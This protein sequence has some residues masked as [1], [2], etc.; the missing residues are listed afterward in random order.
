MN[1]LTH[2][3]SL[4]D[5]TQAL[6]ANKIAFGTLLS[7]LPYALLHADFD[8]YW[9]ETGVP[10]SLFNGVLQVH[11]QSQ[12]LLPAVTRVITHFRRRNIPFHWHVGPCSYAT[13]LGDLLSAHG[14]KHVEDEP[15]MY[16]DLHLLRAEVPVVPHFVI[17]EVTTIEQIHQWTRVWGYG[18]P[19][20]VIQQWDTIYTRLLARSQGALRLFLGIMEEK[21][22]ATTALFFAAGVAS[23]EHIVTIQPFRQR[24]I[25]TAMTHM[26]MHEARNTGY[27]IGVLTASPFGINIYQRAGFKECCLVSTYEWGPEQ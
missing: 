11:R 18:G 26:A 8:V 17:E 16:I 9:F 5:I 6:D 24:K 22:V 20:E 21:P 23:I 19:E 25:G 14:I 10:N 3:S 12:D 4:A 13:N 1:I 7:Y 27:H 2:N 15:G